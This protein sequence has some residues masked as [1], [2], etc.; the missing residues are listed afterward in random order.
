MIAII[1]YGAGNLQS[2]R[3]ALDFIGCPGTVHPTLKKYFLQMEQ[4]FRELERLEAQWRRWNARDLL[5]Q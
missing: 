3:N 5:I 1:D 2:V 4:Y